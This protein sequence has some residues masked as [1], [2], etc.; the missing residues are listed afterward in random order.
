MTYKKCIGCGLILQD[1]DITK[2]GYTP[3]IDKQLCSRCFKLKHYGEYKVTTKNNNDYKK[4]INSISNNNLIL[5]ISDIM[6]LNLDNIELFN[7][8]LLVLTKRDTLPKSIID[9]KIKKYINKRYKNIIDIEI[10]SSIHNY[11]LDNLLNKIYKYNNNKD[12]YL[13]GYTNSGK[14]TLL[15]KI[16]KNYTNSNIN[17]TTSMYPSTTLDKIEINLNDKL[18][19]IDTPGLINEQS[20]IN[21]LDNKLIKRF[22]IKKEIKPRTFQIKDSGSIIID[23]IIRIDYIT[24][25]PNS[26]T[27]YINNG[28]IV[29]KLSKNN[30][31]LKDKINKNITLSSNKD[32]VIDDICFIKFTKDIKLNIYTIYDTNIRVRDNL[33]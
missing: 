23:N 6:Y 12:I 15:N 27:I 13:V 18:T 10:I 22:N 19:L 24:K 28:V 29:K 4:I 20:I 2:E 21:K 7:K 30:N 11:N 26:M 31:I 14:S 32:I 25:E 16:I 9:D 33:I 1:K 3:N 8:I 17:I 5:Y